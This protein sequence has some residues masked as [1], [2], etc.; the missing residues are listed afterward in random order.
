MKKYS[1]LFWW[2]IFFGTT[3]GWW[4]FTAYSEKLPTPCVIGSVI[5]FIFFYV[6]LMLPDEEKYKQLKK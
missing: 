5:T 1:N 4:S 2:L 3:A 6:A